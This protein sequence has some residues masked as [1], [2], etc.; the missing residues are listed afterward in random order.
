M[1]GLNPIPETGCNAFQSL[2]FRMTNLKSA[3]EFDKDHF[4]VL[5]F[6]F[7]HK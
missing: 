5:C 1:N 4:L 6:S 2:E 3:S 7:V